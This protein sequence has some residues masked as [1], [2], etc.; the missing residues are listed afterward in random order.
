MRSSNAEIADR[1]H[2]GITTVKTHITNLM[3]QTGATNQVAIRRAPSSH[4]RSPV[5]PR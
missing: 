1:L 3:T 5:A 4:R 2:V